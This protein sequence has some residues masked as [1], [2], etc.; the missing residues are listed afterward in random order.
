MV[1]K[2]KAGKLVEAETKKP[3]GHEFIKTGIPGLDSLFEYGIPKNTS[4]LIAGGTGSG[5]TL[6]CLQILINAA[7]EG[8]K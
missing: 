5:K 2:I 1:K 6:L 3:E 7:K 8:K 4:S